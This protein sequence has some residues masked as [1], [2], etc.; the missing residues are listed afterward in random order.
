MENSPTRMIRSRDIPMS[1]EIAEV[2]GADVEVLERAL[3]ALRF[4]D[5]EA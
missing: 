3:E 1:E 4:E 5:D 2:T